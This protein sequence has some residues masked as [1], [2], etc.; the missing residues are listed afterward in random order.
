MDKN[1]T[2]RL[3]DAKLAG[4]R[5]G[6]PHGSGRP[7]CGDRF[8]PDWLPPAAARSPLLI[9]LVRKPAEDAFALHF[10]GAYSSLTTFG[11]LARPI[12]ARQTRDRIRSGNRADRHLAFAWRC[13][14]C[15][16]KQRDSPQGVVQRTSISRCSECVDFRTSL[17]SVR[18]SAV[19]RRCIITCPCTRA[20][21]CP[22]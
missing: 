15:D 21:T 9:M 16:A 13:P 5:N 11:Q 19:P 20:S 12:T 14:W 10:S 17:L 6:F 1:V 3:S 4:R 22:S 2:W 8:V 7:I 18:Q